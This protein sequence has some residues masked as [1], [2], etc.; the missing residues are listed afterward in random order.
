MR[1]GADRFDIE[2]AAGMPMTIKAGTA[3][4][5][6]TTAGDVT[7]EGNNITIKAKNELALEG[8]RK[9]TLKGSGRS[10]SRATRSRSRPTATASVEASGPLALKG[11]MVA[12]N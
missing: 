8:R 9:A 11:A 4:F 5:E 7:I 6:I 3:K 10:R 1:L 12:I 2:V